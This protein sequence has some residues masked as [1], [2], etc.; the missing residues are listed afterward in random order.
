MSDRRD[1][2]GGTITLDPRTAPRHCYPVNPAQVAAGDDL[3][4]DFCRWRPIILL[5]LIMEL[6]ATVLTLAGGV[7]FALWYRFVQVSL[8]LQWVGL[9][10]AAVL[11]G[12]RRWL[13]FAPPRV[14]FFVAW[15]LLFVVNGMISLA[16][17]QVLKFADMGF[18]VHPEPLLYFMMRHLLTGAVVSLMV[19]RYFW[20]QHQWRLQVLAEGES[21]YQALQARIR[22]HFLF[23]SLNSIAALVGVR[24]Q[25]AEALIEDMAELLRAG[26]D[27]RS[28]LVPLADEIALVRAYLRIEQERLGERLTVEWDVPDD[29]LSSQVPLLSLQP[30]VENALYHG[31][32]RMSVPGVVQ[33]RAKKQPTGLTIE[34]VNPR[35]DP[36]AA[37]HQGQRIA[38]DN[39]AQRLA[40][41]YGDKARLDL[42]E[43]GDHYVARLS[44]PIVLES[45]RQGGGEKGET[46][47]ED[48]AVR[49]TP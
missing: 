14:V 18:R 20:L 38:T 21:R 25:S 30:L 11:C 24:P 44:L 46:S 19:L 6:V 23:N 17:Y 3:I 41:I 32:E 39:I 29:I 2:H 15:M 43:Q 5:A 48:R 36:G 47:Q 9:C 33:I 37:P 49:T 12:A 26:L 45:S 16:G 31:I 22:P 42:G 4:P 7:G 8:Y 1:R 34:V 27:A 10:S 13:R 35:P 28:R 40:L